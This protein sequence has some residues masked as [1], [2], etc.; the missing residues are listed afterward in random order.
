MVAVTE[1]IDP[2]LAV[3][4]GQGIGMNVEERALLESLD[5]VGIAPGEP[6]Y[7]FTV[8]F[9]RLIARV[10]TTV[11]RV[12]SVNQAAHEAARG[13]GAEMAAAAT[14]HLQGEL[15]RQARKALQRVSRGALLGTAG[16]TLA[17]AGG[18]LLG[19]YEIGRRTTVGEVLV[20]S[21]TMAAAL[22]ENPASAAGWGE[23]I[24]LNDYTAAKAHGRCWDD[25]G[26]QA[27][28][29]VVWSRPPTP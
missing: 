15:A 19:G 12:E 3:A 13:A 21:A 18:L 16:L 27:C 20:A 2:E 26:G 8:L 1:R 11:S 10:T 28:Q 23:V 6:L 22:R 4:A 17:A 24:R 5:V 7:R 29:I 14:V 9:A 25:H